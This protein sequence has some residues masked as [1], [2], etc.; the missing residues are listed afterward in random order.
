[1]CVQAMRAS[2]LP[3]CGVLVLERLLGVL[4]EPKLAG[5]FVTQDYPVPPPAGAAGGLGA[6]LPAL[7]DGL[8]ALGGGAWRWVGESERKLR[9]LPLGVEV[10]GG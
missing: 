1:M 8:P 3:G 4:R 9:R 2:A 5:W 6:A 7:T 10:S